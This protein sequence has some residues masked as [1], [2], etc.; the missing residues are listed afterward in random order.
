MLNPLGCVPTSR[1]RLLASRTR[2]MNHVMSTHMVTCVLEVVVEASQLQTI[3][4]ND[5]HVFGATH[6]C[7]QRRVEMMNVGVP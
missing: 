7:I 4:S 5:K 3:G 6:M 2:V 1:A